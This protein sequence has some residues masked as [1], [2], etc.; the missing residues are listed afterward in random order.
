MICHYRFCF[1]MCRTRL[2]DVLSLYT[3][4]EVCQSP[5]NLLKG[6]CV[7]LQIQFTALSFVTAHLN[8]LCT[9]DIM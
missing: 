7:L 5:G 3:H 6:F 9:K 8:Y 4:V 2:Y 1:I